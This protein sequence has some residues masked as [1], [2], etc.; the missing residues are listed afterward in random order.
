MDYIK[1]NELEKI[2]ILDNVTVSEKD[3]IFLIKKNNIK[4]LSFLLDK[5]AKLPY[6]KSNNIINELVL[7]SR[8]EFIEVLLSK[9]EISSEINI[10]HLISKSSSFGKLTLLKH[11]INQ[12]NVDITYNKNISFVNAYNNKKEKICEYL[13]KFP[14]MKKSLKEFNNDIY[15]EFIKSENKEKISNF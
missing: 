10:T 6:M 8:I 3:I 11:L 7:R 5:Q 12:Y 4:M 15:N 14:E 13:W 1:N 9:K 2:E